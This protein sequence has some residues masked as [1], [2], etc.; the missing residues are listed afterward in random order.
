MEP[1]SE[2]DKDLI[3]WIYLSLSKW[4]PV[5]T[6]KTTFSNFKEGFSRNMNFL[7]RR[8]SSGDL[9]GDLDDDRDS[10]IFTLKKGPSPSAPSSP[11]KS[12]VQNITRGLFS[13]TPAAAPKA[14]YNKDRCKTLLVIDD[15]HTDW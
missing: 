4:D 10:S 3:S 12:S 9:Q 8:F 13:S 2:E 5:T 14:T 7:R 15:P 1:S 6:A 11:S